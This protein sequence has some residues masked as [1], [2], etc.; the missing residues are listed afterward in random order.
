M[1]LLGSRIAQ[2]VWLKTRKCAARTLPRHVPLVRSTPE[3]LGN[4]RCA[5]AAFPASSEDC[6]GVGT[7][8]GATD[9]QDWIADGAT[10]MHTMKRSTPMAEM[11]AA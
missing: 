9:A 7:Q 3:E 1:L 6:M 10:K 11:P 2:G 4:N 5:T 8:S